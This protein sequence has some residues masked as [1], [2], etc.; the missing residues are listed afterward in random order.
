MKKL[1]EKRKYLGFYIDGTNVEFIENLKFKLR[2]ENVSSSDIINLA[3]ECFK[4]QHLNDE[5]KANLKKTE[6]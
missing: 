2:K 6:D 1:K 3:I 4:T 5:K